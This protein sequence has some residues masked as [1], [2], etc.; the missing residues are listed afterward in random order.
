MFQ[1]QMASFWEGVK[2]DSVP[3]ARPAFFPERAYE[4]LKTLGDPKGDY[5][6]RLLLDYRL[7]IGAVHTLLGPNASSAQL[8]AVNVPESYVHWVDPG[9][10]YNQVGYYEVPNARVVY[11]IGGETR[12]FGI[13]SMI[14]WRGAWYIIHLGATFR[15]GNIPVLD[16]PSSG[17]GTSAPSS[18]C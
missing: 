12:S 14:S 18:T 1:A 17:P 8:V 13:A 10:C 2:T 5:V 7:D 11:R 16:N 9:A 3:A 4:Q 6:I 15:V